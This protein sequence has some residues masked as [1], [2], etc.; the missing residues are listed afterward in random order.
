MDDETKAL[1]RELIAQNRELVALNR[2][3]AY[4]AAKAAMRDAFVDTGGAPRIDRVKV[5]QNLDGK[6][7]QREIASQ[8]SVNQST[9]S[10]WGREWQRLGLIDDSGKAVFNLSDYLP[11]IN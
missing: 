2:V 11:E 6:Q 8:A 5:Y 1:L 4:P 9:V 7:T 3:A 10:R